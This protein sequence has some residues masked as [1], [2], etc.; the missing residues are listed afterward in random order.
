MPTAQNFPRS[1]RQ[2][3]GMFRYLK[4]R[5]RLAAFRQLVESKT[6]RQS[7]LNTALSTSPARLVFVCHGN[8]MRSAF[9]TAFLQQRYPQHAHR[10]VGAGTHAKD[11][12]PAQDSA[13]RV[14][15]ELGVSLAEHSA[16]SLQSVE[17][18][19]NDVVVCMDRANV[20]N[21]IAVSAISGRKVFLVGDII[22]TLTSGDREIRDP[23]SRGDLATRNA[24]EMAQKYA[25]KWY[26]RAG[27]R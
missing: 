13:L 17:L 24:F 19:E 5:A 20:A 22:P 15:Q 7:R 21:T 25:E 10:I 3:I 8:I 9:A 4:W 26:Q 11:G 16:K 12:R 27:I 1:A 2:Y 6:T 18:T 14:A 23:Y